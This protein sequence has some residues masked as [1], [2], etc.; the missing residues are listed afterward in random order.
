MKSAEKKQNS[1]LPQL[2]KSCE[3]ITARCRRGAR[4]SFAPKRRDALSCPI[5]P[6]GLTREYAFFLGGEDHRCR[7]SQHAIVTPRPIKPLF[8]M[9]ERKRFFEPRIEHSVRKNEVR[10]RGTG[11][12]SPCSEAEVLP[13]PID[14]HAIV[15]SAIFSQPRQQVG[16]VAITRSSF[17]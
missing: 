12:T 2:W 11:I 13:N 1:L 15:I 3:K 4:V 8:E 5:E 14:N 10:D 16:R 17:A 6:K 9:L 7:V